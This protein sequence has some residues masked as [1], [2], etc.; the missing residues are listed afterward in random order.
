MKELNNVID[1]KNNLTND[2]IDFLWDFSKCE[3]NEKIKTEIHFSLVDF[4]SAYFAGIK[5][6]DSKIKN[7]INLIDSSDNY[8]SLG[9]QQKLSLENVAL[10]NGIIGHYAELDDGHRKAMLHPGVV[11]FSS[12]LAWHQKHPISSHN[13]YKAVLVGFETC[14]RLAES[15]QPN[16]KL[17]GFHA[18]GVFGSIGAAVACAV[19]A[20]STKLQLK[21]TLSAAV[22]SASG[23][24]RVIKNTSELKPFNVG[25]AAKNAI[26]AAQ[27]G[28]ADF[29]GPI[30]VLDG[31]LGFLSMYDNNFDK[32]LLLEINNKPKLFEIYRKPYAAC[33]HCHSAID[34]ALHYR[35]KIKIKDINQVKIRTYGI[36][37]PGHDHTEIVGMNSAKMSTPF[38]FAVALYSGKAGLRQFE[39]EYFENN[40]IIE[41]TKK[42]SVESD[43]Y[44]DN[45]FPDV[46]GAE[47]ELSLNSGKTMSKKVDL[48]K[49]EPETA[50]SFEEI[51]GKFYESAVFLGIKKEKTDKIFL[52]CTDSNIDLNCVLRNLQDLDLLKN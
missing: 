33:R 2:F 50:L 16:A 32:K 48:P 31:D 41:L 26:S 4:L 25:N 35:S 20:D 36:G 11:I 10:V 34:I 27:L 22:T 49:G 18:T 21:N 8:H 1:L 12:L 38:S 43:A 29:S 44:F 51:Q 7:L 24:L 14:I 3:I 6:G 46:R 45:H 5:I 9:I 30:E 23:I 17:K 47:I 52:S 19:A 42:I 15:T 37:I 40:K 13:F 39:K 28:I